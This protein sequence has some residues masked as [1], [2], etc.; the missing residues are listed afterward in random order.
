MY[1]IP[2]LIFNVFNSANEKLDFL[3]FR[4]ILKSNFKNDHAII[5]TPL[6]YDG[7]SYNIS[8]YELI[9]RAR[10]SSEIFMMDYSNLKSVFNGH[11]IISVLDSE[12]LQMV[13][14]GYKIWKDVINF[15]VEYS[16]SLKK[17]LKETKKFEV[18]GELKNIR[19]EIV[20]ILDGIKVDII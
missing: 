3:S 14:D 15:P 8:K 1:Q 2:N 19:I 7:F 18:S 20:G 17:S 12:K 6:D 16:A 13:I 9:K 5:S 4:I 10:R 11:I